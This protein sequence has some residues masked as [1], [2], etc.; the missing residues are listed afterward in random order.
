MRKRE[1]G[2]KVSQGASIKRHDHTQSPYISFIFVTE[3][4]LF[5]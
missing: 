1:R 2:K 3:Y 5:M 4:I